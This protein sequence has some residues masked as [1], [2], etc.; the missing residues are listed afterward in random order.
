MRRYF[1]NLMHQKEN[2]YLMLGSLFVTILML[3][4][5]M[6]SGFFSDDAINS[7][8]RGD[9][10]YNHQSLTQGIL[11][12]ITSWLSM[13]RLFPIASIIGYLLFT[14]AGDLIVYKSLII[15]SI[16]LNIFLFSYFIRIITNSPSLSILSMLIIPIFF[17]FR[18]YHDPILSFNMLQ[19]NVFLFIIISL[20]LLVFYIKRTKRIYLF[21]SLCMYLLCVLT[22]EIALSFFLLHFLIIYLYSPNKNFISILKHSAPYFLISIFCI[23][24]TILL[25]INLGIPIIVG[26]V[27][28]ASSPSYSGIVPNVNIQ[29]VII[30][31]AKQTVAAFPLSYQINKYLSGPPRNLDDIMGLFSAASIMIAAIYLSLSLAILKYVHREISGKRISG[32][33]VWR[34]SIIGLLLLILPG[35]LVSLS[36]KYQ[37][38]LHWGIGYIPVYIS[39]F[40]MAI[41]TLCII[42]SILIKTLDCSKNIIIFL[43]ILIAM[44]ISMTGALTYTSNE[45][46]IENIN[47]VWLYPRLVIEDALN[48]G[49]FKFVPN[50]S[51][52]LVDGRNPYWEQ[53]GFYLMHSGVRLRSVESNG[54]NSKPYLSDNLPDS[55]LINNASGVYSFRFS[56]SDNIFYLRY[57]SQSRGEG[58]AVLGT[59]EN[60]QASKKMLDYVSGTSA[61]IYVHYVENPHRNVSIYGRTKDSL[62]QMYEPFWLD[63]E[64]L[65][66]LLSGKNWDLFFISMSNKT[67]DLQS[68]QVIAPPEIEDFSNS[69]NGLIYVLLD[70]W[71]QIENWSGI[72][73]QWMQDNANILIHSNQNCTANL[74]LQTISFYHPRTLEA[75][76]GG[77]LV[78][79]VAVPT[80]IINVNVPLH[81]TR[82]ANIVRLTVPEG[83]DKPSDI[84]EL[85]NLDSRCLSVAVQNITLIEKKSDQLDYDNGFHGVE[86]WSGT[87]TRWMQ[88]NATLQINSSEDRTATLRLNAQSFYRNRTLEIFSG[89]VLAAQVAVP[90]SV[91]NVSVPIQL[92][93]RANTV[94]L[95]VPEGC[96]RPSDKPELNNSDPRCLSVAV[97]NLTVA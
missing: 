38:E 83:C 54:A 80:N 17:Q 94:H 16:I 7:F 89:G 87:P 24:L 71:N 11:G 4:P 3:L 49:L 20:I 29:D 15:L 21:L 97:Q 50:D 36:T 57:G 81:L 52:L 69:Q 37:K 65:K 40:G 44:I 12:S 14:F 26:G 67:I 39:Y 47:H 64:E 25:Q 35:V 41:V 13:G 23:L 5:L 34:L 19:Q 32:L 96:E 10:Q 28:H 1:S 88:A 22:Y 84:K 46:V 61:F 31:F 63:E 42:A 95:H 60:L 79:R 68:L 73:T 74:S 76:S 51:I 6:N 70:G 56:K 93:K 43:L 58:Y 8:V 75:Y 45:M 27:A 77:E 66:L 92:A 2:L 48:D 82:G 62:P 33:D 78:D 53:P 30:T 91:I 72:P 9:L 86:N 59:I 55:S 90:T 18:E 85:H